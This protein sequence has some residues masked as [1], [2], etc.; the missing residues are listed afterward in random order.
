MNVVRERPCQ[1]LHHRVEAPF[2]VEID[3]ISHRVSNW[4]LGGFRVAGFGGDLPRVGQSVECVCGLPFQGFDISFRVEGEVVRAD[5]QERSFAARFRELGDRQRQLMAHFVEELVRGSMVPARETIQRIDAPVTPVSLEPEADPPGR[6]PLRRWPTKTV[7]MSALHVLL[8]TLVL[9]YAVVL[10]Y[11]HFFRLEIQSAVVAAPLQVVTAQGGGRIDE[12]LV[13]QGAFV[14]AG[15]PVMLIADHQLEQEIDAATV[16]VERAKSA[17]ISLDG[18]LRDE[19]ERLRDYQTASETDIG[20]VRFEIRAL[21]AQEATA[22]SR[23]NRMAALFAKGWVNKAEREESESTLQ[24]VVA[25]LQARRLQLDQLQTLA[26]RSGTRRFY[27]GERS[28]GEIGRLET[29]KKLAEAHVQSAEQE[30]LTL[31][32]HRD[33]L[34]VR[35]PFDGRVLEIAR[36]SGS[37]IDRGDPLATFERTGEQ[38]I[39]AY[40]T[41]DEILEVGLDDPAIVY[42]PALDERVRAD[43]VGIDRTSG[44]V[45]EQRHRY[46]W[47]GPD[48]RSA[49]VRLRFAGLAAEERARFAT[50]LPA[51]VVFER[52]STSELA[53][54]IRDLFEDE[55]D[56]ALAQVAPVAG[57]GDDP[58]R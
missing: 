53:A 16:R 17:A 47:R 58:S 24:S 31:I 48:D 15:Q 4:S 5:R 36:S 29:E 10:L 20:R 54:R 6:M 9:G 37:A 49:L 12:V 30:L 40:L 11:G 39:E 51:V 32:Q 19:H 45:D 7:A 38:A 25:E 50:G 43:V 35:A 42:F 23:R 27:N 3:G 46:T 26:D 41:Q 57:A 34:A 55:A 1:R 56:P 18:K 2:Y 8:G 22:R 14:A 44:F 13:P 28:L 52:R 21:E 33:R